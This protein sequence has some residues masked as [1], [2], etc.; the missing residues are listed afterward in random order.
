MAIVYAHKIKGS[1]NIFYIGIGISEKRAYSKLNRNKYW[2]NI[3]NKYGYDIEILFKNISYE[4]A[5]LKESELILKYGRVDLKT[6]CLVNLTNGGDGVLGYKYTDEVKS[7]MSFIKKGIAS[8]RKGVVLS[9]E[10]KDKISNS[11]IGKK[12]SESHKLKIGEGNKGKKLSEKHVL[13]LI[14]SNKN[15]I[16]S[17]DTRKKMSDSKLQMSQETKIKIGLAT[18]KRRNN[19]K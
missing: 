10:T 11:K 8:P 3:V 5:N 19:L 7:K 18:K 9:Q 14:E 2:K 15:R 13:A 17:E 16:I 6:G 1:E 4:E 12:K